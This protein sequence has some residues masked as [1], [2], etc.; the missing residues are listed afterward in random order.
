MKDVSSDLRRKTEELRG[1][2]Y[3]AMTTYR[4]LEFL[5]GVYGDYSQIFSTHKSLQG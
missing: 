1:Q 4:T 5:I 2:L 3:F